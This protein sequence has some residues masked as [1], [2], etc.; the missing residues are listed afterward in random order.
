MTLVNSSKSALERCT[1][2]LKGSKCKVN[3]LHQDLV[4]D[5]LEHAISVGKNNFSS[6]S[7]I[8]EEIIEALKRTENPL[9]PGM[10]RGIKKANYVISSLGLSQLHTAIRLHGEYF[11][12]AG[13]E[14][15]LWKKLND[16]LKISLQP[17]LIRDL[18]SLVHSLGG[19]VC[20]IDSISGY[21]LYE[22]P[23]QMVEREVFDNIDH[24]FTTR[25]KEKW[26]WICA[27]KFSFGSP[28]VYQIEHYSLEPKSK[29][30]S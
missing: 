23:M 15:A 19:K 27:H 6:K 2:K 8:L 1:S 13:K 21:E 10:L 11:I 4:S 20:F 5:Y 30:D 22:P 24:L 25:K 28:V 12:E 17:R 18:H 29:A 16:Q 3:P 7:A 9:L 26:E 14:T